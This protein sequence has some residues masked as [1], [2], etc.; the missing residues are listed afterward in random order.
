MV[1]NYVHSVDNQLFYKLALATSGGSKIS[2]KGFPQVVDPR[3][4]GRGKY[5]TLQVVASSLAI[6]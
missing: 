1:D 4:R 2:G 3:C 6:I 5:L